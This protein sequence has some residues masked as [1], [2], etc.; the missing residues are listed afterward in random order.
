[1]ATKPVYI[2]TLSDPDTKQVMYVGQTINPQS[3]L[4]NHCRVEGAKRKDEWIR[5]L[6]AAGK[7]PEMAVID[8]CDKEQA[9]SIEQQWIAYYSHGKVLMNSRYGSDKVNHPPIMALYAAKGWFK[10]WICNNAMATPAQWP[11]VMVCAECEER[12]RA[13][14]AERAADP[15]FKWDYDEW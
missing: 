9:D 1:M 12:T 11:A 5:H 6:L 2:Y 4:M 15:D 8:T 7:R 3:R 13:R 10:C 14:D